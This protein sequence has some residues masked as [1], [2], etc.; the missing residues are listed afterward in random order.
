M[1]R[2]IN[3]EVAICSGCFLGGFK[4]ES[5]LMFGFG[6]DPRHPQGIQIEFA[7]D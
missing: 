4:F 3:A 6:G 2:R 5:G 7:S 1:D